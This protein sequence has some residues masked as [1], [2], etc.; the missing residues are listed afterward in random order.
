MRGDFRRKKEELITKIKC[1]DSQE[2]PDGEG[3]D[4]LRAQLENELESLFQEEE[5]YWQQRGGEKHVLEGDASTAFF[6][7]S[8]NSSRR[9]K[10]ILSLEDAG[11]L[12]TDQQEIRR[13]IDDFFL[14]S[15]RRAWKGVLGK[16][17]FSCQNHE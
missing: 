6:H 13:L 11:D 3:I 1:L 9:K 17:R 5:M 2:G 10:T 8:A 4:Q 12:V 7:L 15:S 14:G 16:P